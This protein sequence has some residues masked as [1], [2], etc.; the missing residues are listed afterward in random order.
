MQKK[1]TPT[2]SQSSTRATS[3]AAARKVLDVTPT[4]GDHDTARQLL[5]LYHNKATAP[6]IRYL[7]SQLFWDAT[8]FYGLALP[9]N[10]TSKWSAYWPL[11]LAKLRTHGCLPTRI[12]YT[13][14]P[15]EEE[16]AQL[17]AEEKEQR[18][19][20]AIFDLLRNDALPVDTV[21]RLFDD[22]IEIL[23]HAHPSADFEVFRVAWPRA[24][25]AL[26]EDDAR[27]E[28]SRESEEAQA[29]ITRDKIV[30][31]RSLHQTQATERSVSDGQ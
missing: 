3:L 1:D 9:S 8:Q 31:R 23:D 15:D 25:A 27:E 18:D 7:L 20:R 29:R 4:K 19:A 22:V 26:K 14:Q 28:T 2:H 17:D 10:Y 21:N 11:L 5:A 24:L 13:W 16:A 12:N 6:M 30:T